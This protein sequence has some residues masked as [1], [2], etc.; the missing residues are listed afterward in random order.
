MTNTNYHDIFGFSNIV[1]KVY[2]PRLIPIN[3]KLITI[4]ALRN[5]FLKYKNFYRPDRI[6]LVKNEVYLLKFCKNIN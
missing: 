5:L 4:R 6:T 1:F 2:R 3:E